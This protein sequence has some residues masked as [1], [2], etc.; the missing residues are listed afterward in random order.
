M[1][2]AA[3]SH[4]KTDVIKICFTHL[5]YSSDVQPEVLVISVIDVRLCGGEV[6]GA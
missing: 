5:T 6:Y 1:I 4:K 2:Y 3:I